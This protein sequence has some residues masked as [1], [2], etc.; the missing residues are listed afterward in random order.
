MDLRVSRRGRRLLRAGTSLSV[1]ID[2]T[3]TT[4]AGTL[5]ESRAL[6]LP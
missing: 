4:R 3:F 1:T 5:E 6:V 2:A